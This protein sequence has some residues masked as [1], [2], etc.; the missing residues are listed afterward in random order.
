[1][2]QEFI[3][4]HLP[5]MVRKVGISSTDF[6]KFK[7][8][9]ASE[10]HIRYIYC[11]A[12]LI[13]GITCQIQTL[14]MDN[15]GVD[16]LQSP[17]D[18]NT[19][20]DTFEQLWGVESAYKNSILFIHQTNKQWLKEKTMSDTNLLGFQ[21]EVQEIEQTFHDGMSLILFDCISWKFDTDIGCTI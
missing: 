13:M 18:S 9:K 5:A 19:G 10:R 21:Q 11:I 2:R 17:I 12:I 14:L 7:L 16:S 3:V 6:E 15:G 1:M 20:E 4:W 8:D